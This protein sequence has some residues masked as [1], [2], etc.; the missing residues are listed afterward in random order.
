MKKMH[1]GSSIYYDGY[2]SYDCRKNLLPIKPLKEVKKKSY[3]EYLTTKKMSTESSVYYDGCSI[4]D[5]PKNFLA[6]KPFK[7]VKKIKIKCLS[8]KFNNEENEHRTKFVLRRAR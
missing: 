1:T 7:E 8:R 3:L 6:I 4:Y 5:Y 2:G